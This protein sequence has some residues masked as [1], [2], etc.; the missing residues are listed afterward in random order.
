MEILQLLSSIG[1][2]ILM[3]LLNIFLKILC[4]LF[5]FKVTAVIQHGRNSI[6]GDGNW[7]CAGINTYTPMA[8]TL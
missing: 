5:C 6:R 1:V 3:Q 7:F 2:P 8:P 4:G